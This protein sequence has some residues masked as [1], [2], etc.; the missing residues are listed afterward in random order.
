MDNGKSLTQDLTQEAQFSGVYNLT[1]LFQKKSKG[2]SDKV[3][4]EKLKEKFGGVDVVMAESLLSSFALTDHWVEYEGGQKV[5]SQLIITECSPVK[6]PLGDAIARTQFWD[7]PDGVELLDSCPWQVMIGDFMARGL[8]V[9]ERAA[10]LSDWL[11][12]ALELFP[13]CAAVYFNPSGKLLTAEAARKNPYSGPSRFI[14]GGV[15]ARFFNIQDSDDKVVDTLG[16]YALGLPDVQYHFHTLDPNVVVRHA[17]NTAI[18]QFENDAPIESGHTIEGV[19]E[20]SLWRCRYEQS[21]IQPVRDV[22]DV[23]AG[24]FAAGTRE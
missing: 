19:E 9:L 4:L 20:G 13:A 2:P 6:E 11:E 8:S 18:Y 3:L 15:N 1:L 10:I 21:L 16:L 7:C 22:L 14:H 12:V 17:Y 23:A 24:E 5:P